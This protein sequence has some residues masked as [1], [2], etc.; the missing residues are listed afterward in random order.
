MDRGPRTHPDSPPEDAAARPPV[1]APRPRTG[2]LTVV[3]LAVIGAGLLVG[4]L[5]PDGEA[6]GGPLVDSPAPEIVMDDFDGGRWTLSGQLADRP[7]PTVV[8]LWA[9][10]CLPCREEIPELARFSVRN[11]DVAVV[12][13]AVEDR[14]EDARRMAEELAPPYPMGIDSTGRLRERYPGFGIPATFVIDGQGVVRHQI[15][16]P[17]T[18][19]ELEELIG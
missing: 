11:P 4:G 6:E 2:H 16:R 8:N 13:V 3:F 19:E 12:G 1:P 9:S 17:V 14:P 10:W 5:I 7:G 18:A 15:E